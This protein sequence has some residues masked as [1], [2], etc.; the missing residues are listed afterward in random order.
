[1]LRNV[2]SKVVWMARATT[3]V[4]G[5]AIM[6]A[7]VVGVASAAFG[8]NGGNFILGSL[9]NT[10]TALTRLVGN[11]NGSAMQVVN[12][13]AGTDDSA[14]SLSVQSGEA[15]MRVNSSKV[16]T[17]LNADKL[18]GQEAS[19]L[20]EPRGYAHVK[21][22]GDV[23]TVY[24]SKGVNDVQIPEGQ[25]SLYCFDLAFTPK[26]AVGSGHINNSAVVST[27]TPPNDGLNTCPVDY[28]DAAVK[29]Y[30]SDTGMAAAINFQVVFE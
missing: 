20:A 3:T 19:D 1:M 8:A 13:N 29:T 14:L 15:P 7:L 23:D 21:L 22:Q 25:T 2:G 24:P 12:N 11:V 10:A 6:L 26:T 27:V 17:N 9:N 4:V 5:L 18:D 30:G 16:V 28:R